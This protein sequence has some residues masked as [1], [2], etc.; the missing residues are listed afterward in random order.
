MQFSATWM[1]LES[2]MLSEVE[3]RP[4]QNDLPHIQP[5]IKYSKETTKIQR[6]QKLRTV[7][8]HIITVSG[9][10]AGVENMG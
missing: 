5:I 7:H 6:Q 3:E 1:G 10:R 9:C 2:I 4:T 8:W